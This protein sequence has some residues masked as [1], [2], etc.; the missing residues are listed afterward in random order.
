MNSL[1]AHFDRAAEDRRHGAVEIERRL[2]SG[3]PADSE[4]WA[5]PGLASGAR[6]LLEGQ[7]AMANLRNLVSTRISE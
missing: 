1:D 2:I 7:P 6:R 5:A 4:H 3:L